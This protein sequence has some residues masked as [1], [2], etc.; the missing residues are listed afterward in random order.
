MSAVRIAGL[1]LVA[2]GMVVL[3]WGGLF[4]TRHK[5]VANAGPWEVRSQKREG[6]SLPPIVGAASLAAG[7]ILV[8]AGGRR[9]RV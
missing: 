8:L 7:I 9:E 5:T 3:L 2:V 4:W 6:V 1:A